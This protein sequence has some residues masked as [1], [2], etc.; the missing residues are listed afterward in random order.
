MNPF[1]MVRQAFLTGGSTVAEAAIDPQVKK[2][3]KTKD[4]NK[5]KKKKKRR[6]SS[7]YS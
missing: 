6:S 3:S 1:E 2:S 7:R 4:R 5:K